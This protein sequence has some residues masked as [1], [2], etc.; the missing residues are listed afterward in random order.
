MDQ[1]LCACL[2]TEVSI[3]VA[4]PVSDKAE[5]GNSISGTDMNS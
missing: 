4:G 1:L 3:Q 5:A 2:C